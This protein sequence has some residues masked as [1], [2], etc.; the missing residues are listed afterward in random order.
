MNMND[1]QIAESKNDESQEPPKTS[2]ADPIE[3]LKKEA[4]DYKD[5]WQRAL[6]DYQNL[7][8]EV[9]RQRSEWATMSELQILEEFLPVYSNF[10]K[11][12]ESNKEDTSWSK[13]IGFIM[14]QFGD[15]LRNHGIEEMKT[16]GELF[17]ASKHEIVG[18]ELS[19]QPEHVI[20]KEID[21]GYTMKGKVIKV[22]KVVVAKHDT[23]DT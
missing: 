4:A 23:R 2:A 3:T 5:G 9:A 18:E 17:D 8:K 1:E 22:A 6:Y 19:E 15:V 12:F 10:K 16:V 11:A 21:T 20:L 13:G 14:K 7:Q